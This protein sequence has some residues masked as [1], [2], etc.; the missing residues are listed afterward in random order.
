M[1]AHSCFYKNLGYFGPYPDNNLSILEDLNREKISYCVDLTTSE[2][3]LKPYN[4][5]G[6][7]VKYPITDGDTPEKNSTFID[8][9]YQ[10]CSWLENGE[11]VY[12]HCR[13]GHGR[14]GLVSAAVLCVLLNI[15]PYQAISEIS[16]AHHQRK[17]LRKKWLKMPCPHPKNQRTWLFKNFG[18]VFFGEDSNFFTNRNLN[19]TTYSKFNFWGYDFSSVLHAYKVISPVYNDK[20]ELLFKILLAKF[21]QNYENCQYLINTMGKTIFYNSFDTFWGI[22]ESNFEGKNMLGYLLSKVRRN[23]SREF[24]MVYNKSNYCV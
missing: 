7:I 9:I 17:D 12:I 5:H 15:H 18:P 22:G 20:L 23:L 1:D 8:L 10:I 4:F 3:N 2:E 21:C 13:G 11:A 16:K 19:I 6:K 24:S 14:S